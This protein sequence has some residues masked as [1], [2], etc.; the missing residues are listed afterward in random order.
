MAIS[1]EYIIYISDLLTPFGE[2]QIKKMFGGAGVYYEG[3]VFALLANNQL[4]FKADD[5]NRPDYE[6]LKL[7]PFRPYPDKPSVM[8]YY[9]VPADVQED[10]DRLVE[11]AQKAFEAALRGKKKK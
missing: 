10:T 9:P 1:D 4:Y 7:V 11:W 5:I 8:P 3:F 6:A 2:V